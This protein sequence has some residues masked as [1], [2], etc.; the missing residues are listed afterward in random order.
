MTEHQRMAQVNGIRSKIRHRKDG[1]DSLFRGIINMLA[2][3]DS[4][5]VEIESLT[6]GSTG[7]LEWYLY[8]SLLKHTPV[9]K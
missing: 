6:R 8:L 1:L 2:E 4:R 9:H 5:F 7:K 3:K